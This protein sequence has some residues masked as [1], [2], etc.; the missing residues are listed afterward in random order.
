MWFGRGRGRGRDRGTTKLN[1]DPC[2]FNPWSGPV[3]VAVADAVAVAVRLTTDAG[4]DFFDVVLCFFM[5]SP[6]NLTQFDAF[7]VDCRKC[8]FF[9]GR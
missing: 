7:W 8:S 1:R 2:F 4:L 3:A 6:D 5:T 9:L